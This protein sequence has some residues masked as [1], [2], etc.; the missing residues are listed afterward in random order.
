MK[1]AKFNQKHVFIKKLATLLH[2]IRRAQK[3]RRKICT[4]LKDTK[5]YL[6]NSI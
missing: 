5:G 6:L 2:T 1:K 3:H 4:L